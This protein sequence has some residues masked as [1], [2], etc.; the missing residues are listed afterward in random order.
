MFIS[1]RV[2]RGNLYASLFLNHEMSCNIVGDF[3]LRSLCYTTHF[4]LWVVSK[5]KGN[6]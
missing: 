6:D 4:I 2:P 3:S 5:Q 1:C